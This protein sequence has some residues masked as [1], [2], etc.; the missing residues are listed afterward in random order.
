MTAQGF[1]SPISLAE[2]EGQI[3]D[4]MIGC[5]ITPPL[6]I[7]MD[8]Q[9]HRFDPAGSKRKDKQNGW[10]VIHQ[11]CSVPA[12]NF[13]D[14]SK[15]PDGK[16]IDWRANI[17]RK[18]RP[19]EVKAQRDALAK[20]RAARDK[21]TAER[22]MEA[23][24]KAQRLWKRAK[25]RVD[26][27]H[28]YLVAKAVPAYGLRQLDD[29]L[30]VPLIDTAGVLH[31]LQHIHP[32]GRK[33]F[34]SGTAKAGHFH[35]IKGNADTVAI[36]EGYATGATIHQLLGWR[37]I[38]A[39]DAG[40]LLGVAKAIRKHSPNSLVVICGDNDHGKAENA[41]ASKARAAAQ[42]INARVA[43]PEFTAQESGTDWNDYAALHGA[44][45]TR[46]ALMLQLSGDAQ[47]TP[48]TD[49]MPPAPPSSD[50]VAERQPTGPLPHFKVDA[51]GT[52]YIGVVEDC[53]ER[54]QAR[55]KFICSPLQ[56]LAVIRDPHGY[57]WGRLVE[58]TDPDNISKRMVISGRKM[59]SQRGD[60]LRGDLMDAGLPAITMDGK[61]QRLLNQYLIETTPEVRA[62]HVRRVG[63]YGRAF[64]LPACTVG[65]PAG[66]FYHF[67]EDKRNDAKFIRA[68]TLDGWRKLVASKAGEH[69][70]L[71][72]AISAAFAGPLIR[73]V[74]EESG[75]LHFT[76]NSSAG[77]TTALSLAS[78]VYGHPE[79]FWRKW[80]TTDVGIEA[81][82][83]DHNDNL[84][85][86]D[87][88]GEADPRIISDAAYMLGSG[89]G[90]VRGR[91]DGTTRAVRR[92]K[93]M[94]LSTGEVGTAAMINAAGGKHRAGHDVRLVEVPADAGRGFG[95]FD[96]TGNYPTAGDLSAGLVSAAREHHGHAGLAFVE[97]IA[98]DMDSATA[99]VKQDIN[100]FLENEVPQ[101]ADGQ[102]VRVA[103]R[104]ALIAAA[105]VLATEYGLTW[106][107]TTAVDEACADAFHAW[108]DKRGTA[109]AL[110][111]KAMIEAVRDFIAQHGGA[112][113]QEL[114]KQRNGDQFTRHPDELIDNEPSDVRI[115]NRAG[116]KKTIDSRRL[117]LIDPGTFR[118]E[119][120]DGFDHQQVCKV[121]LSKSILKEQRGPG[122][123]VKVRTPASPQPMPFIG[124]YADALF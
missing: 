96:S 52:W 86:L 76:S 116:Y 123:A 110:E 78:S 79:T 20:A 73:L 7:I 15:H 83:E 55:P 41:G 40:N 37:V 57:G 106:W 99:R 87:E 56:V 24:Q 85:G 8:G 63:W 5:D 31:G 113:F 81:M 6:H 49:A 100:R 97:R 101:H 95:L 45:K 71:L 59:I 94:V 120:C 105:G 17:S 58:F 51:G 108:L 34:G 2:L 69:K 44:D 66:E 60:E 62:R 53:G 90:K 119:V 124:V 9:L 43:L 26:T 32:N 88:I 4:A 111:P 64:V 33:L 117:Y 38:V 65:D 29:R 3:K 74:N 103:R 36:V 19:D 11:N 54:V 39:F 109:G 115:I 98:A 114:D 70:R 121:L 92:W 68:G 48:P 16:G 104:F 42:A 67:D 22:R 47:P 80:K 1:T 107:Q 72:L 46:S 91:T 28:G 21:A 12:G 75:G 118:R 93:T 13:G 30:L 112:R 50:Q 27:D 122:Y 82:A 89:I 25:R 14:W 10:Y 102:V 84:L 35:R 23:A 77:K 18:L 61:A